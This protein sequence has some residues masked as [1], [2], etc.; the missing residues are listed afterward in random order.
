[1]RVVFFIQERLSLLSSLLLQNVSYFAFW[2]TE[3]LSWTQPPHWRLN[4]FIAGGLFP[5]TSPAVPFI[6]QV[7]KGYSVFYSRKNLGSYLPVT[8]SEDGP[9]VIY[10][11]SWSQCENAVIFDW[12][13]TVIPYFV[14]MYCAFHKVWV[15][16]VNYVKQLAQQTAWTE[17]INPSLVKSISHR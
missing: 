4:S 14:Y 12:E 3:L 17:N 16:E 8:E 5:T 7:K 15:V 10:L 6:P 13:I 11:F 9:F 1:M 2:D